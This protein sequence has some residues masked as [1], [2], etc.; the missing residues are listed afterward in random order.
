MLTSSYFTLSAK[1]AEMIF[2]LENSGSAYVGSGT[3]SLGSRPAL[4]GVTGGSM[5]EACKSSGSRFSLIRGLSDS[6]LRGVVSQVCSFKFG[7]SS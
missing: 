2:F 5:D 7:P 6:T 3:T 1:G 4:C